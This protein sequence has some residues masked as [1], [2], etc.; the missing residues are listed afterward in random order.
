LN[1]NNSDTNKNMIM[2]KE[3]GF[4]PEVQFWEYV[5]LL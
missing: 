5:L 1:N 3:F 2:I 4:N